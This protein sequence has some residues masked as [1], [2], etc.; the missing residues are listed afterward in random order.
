MSHVDPSSGRIIANFEQ[1]RKKLE[2]AID[3][4]CDPS[5]VDTNWAVNMEI[6]DMVNATSY[7]SAFAIA[8][9]RRK[10]K[11]KIPK[12]EMLALTLLEGMIKNVPASHGSVATPTFMK[13][14]VKV[15]L[16]TRKRKKKGV[17]KNL[18]KK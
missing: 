6:V 13:Y 4:A 18:G 14:L 8:A 7:L 11:T 9:I 1:N 2:K 16:D 15:G 5:L 12:I 17:M 10:L 3:K